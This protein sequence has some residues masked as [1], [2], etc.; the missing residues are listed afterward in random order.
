MKQTKKGF[1]IIE[2]VLVLAIGGL[3]FMMVFIALPALQRSQR[4]SQRRED[5]DRMYSAIIEYQKH[6]SGNL[7]FSKGG[8]FDINFATRYID[9][10][11]VYGGKGN[12]SVAGWGSIV[13]LDCGDA[14]TDPDG[15]AYSIGLAQGGTQN[16]FLGDEQKWGK[17]HVIYVAS[18]TKCG[19]NEDKILASKGSRDFVVA[20]TLEGGQIYCKD[21]T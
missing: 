10:S 1:T 3:I 13:Y 17:N 14:F 16:Q 8:K 7:P 19:A 12:D 11:C 6:N 15:S 4:N 21:N 2:V 9:S 5:I 18:K 20:M